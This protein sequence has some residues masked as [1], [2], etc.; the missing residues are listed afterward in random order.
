MVC[1]YVDSVCLCV[2]VCGCVRMSVC[3]GATSRRTGFR[4]RFSVSLCVLLY[5]CFL[6]LLHAFFIGSVTT[7]VR[8]CV[9]IRASVCVRTC[10]CSFMCFCA[11]PRLCASV[12]A[13]VDACC[14]KCL[15]DKSCLFEGCYESI[16]HMYLCLRANLCG[17]TRSPCRVTLVVLFLL[18]LCSQSVSSN[19][20]NGTAG[21]LAG[22]HPL[23]ANV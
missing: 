2:C 10:G 12:H 9:C 8:L 6:G 14:F 22:K 7:C 15:G 11:C 5:L 3:A 19:G 4:E 1:V 23:K 13:F 21:G 18:W 17:C 16:A 20:R